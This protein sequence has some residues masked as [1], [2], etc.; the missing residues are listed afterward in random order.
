MNIL[1]IS[2]FYHDSAAC[3]VR[4]GRIVAA[5][6]EERF[7]RVKNDASFPLRAAEYCLAEAGIGPAD[8]D[9]VVFYEKP[10]EKFDR[11][12]ETWLARAPRGFAHFRQSFPVW[13]KE[14]INHRKMLA[15]ELSALGGKPG[16]WREK[17]RFSG[18][19]F[20]H[21]ASAFYPSPFDEAA[22]LTVDGVGEW[23]TATLASGGPGGIEMLREIRFPHSLGLLYS[24]FTEYLGFE[25]NSG[26]YKV[27]GLAPLGRPVYAELIREH[28]LSL[29]PDGSFRLAMRYFDFLTGKR[30]THRRFHDLLGRPPR[31]PESEIETFHKDVAASIQQVLE[32]ALFAMAGHVRDLIGARHLCLAG[33]VA[34]NCVANGK[35]LRSG[36]FDDIWVQ[37]AAD[38]AGGALGAALAYH[39]ACKGG[40]GTERGGTTGGDAMGGALLGPAWTNDEIARRLDAMGARYQYLDDA[41]LTDRV[42]RELADGAIIGWHQ[43]RMEFGPRALG[44][45][46]ILASPVAPDMKDRINSKVK[47]RESFRPFAPAVPEELAHHWFD[48][49]RPFPY[50]TFTVY[51]RQGEDAAMEG[52]APGIDAS[53]HPATAIPA[54]IHQDGSARVQT[55]AK[56]QMPRFHDLLIQF[57]EHTGCPVLLNTSLNVR[58]EPIV[59][60]PGEAYARMLDSELDCS[61]IGNF[62]VHLSEQH[63]NVGSL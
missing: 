29:N 61:V 53:R 43:G 38:D 39:H 18:H 15:R 9:A 8:I 58:S 54:V 44:A 1:G 2:A 37:P 21:A 41:E 35:L 49:D 20:S 50:M 48:L 62:I 14:K 33:G 45:R 59:C 34:L 11:L 57:G 6:Q 23:S 52:P 40:S 28:L 12:L 3:L 63:N 24:A 7:S 5:A 30:M 27:M 47:R 60:T 16:H 19:H 25:V 51:A 22:I 10:F 32:E 55:V 17:L 4:D 36:L 56:E 46:S 42:A 26:E 13:I 31:E